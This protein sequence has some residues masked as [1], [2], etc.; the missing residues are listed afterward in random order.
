MY[1][2]IVTISLAKED[3]VRLYMGVTTYVD[4]GSGAGRLNHDGMIDLVTGWV[5][6]LVV[7]MRVTGN[8]RLDSFCNVMPTSYLQNQDFDLSKLSALCYISRR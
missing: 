5:C 1:V 3:F 6:P 7:E 8:R 2:G 4:A